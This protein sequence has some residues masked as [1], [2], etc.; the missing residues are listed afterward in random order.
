MAQLKGGTLLESLFALIIITLS[1]L[2]GT[3][4][5]GNVLTSNNGVQKTAALL[6][7]K[8]VAEATKQEKKYFNEVLSDSTYTCVKEISS[9]ESSD[10]LFVL[11]ITISNSAT[12]LIDYR[13]IIIE[14]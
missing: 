2:I 13:E 4:V 5:L 14:E 9:Y 6:F 12:K 11:K 1:F 10:K 7:A 8:K 3:T